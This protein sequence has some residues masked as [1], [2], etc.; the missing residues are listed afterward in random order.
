MHA[1]T[2]GGTTAERV[3]DWSPAWPIALAVLARAV[4]WCFV[5]EGRF[6]SDEESYVRAG[7][8]LLTR[9]EQDLFWPPFTGWLIAAAAWVFHTTDIR[10]IRLVWL[11]MDVACAV[12][13]GR[14]A[15]DV[16]RKSFGHGRRAALVATLATGM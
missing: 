2:A 3:A 13:L 5:P 9:G 14:L 1:G 10:W 6:A 16:A 8:G 7:I 4:A 12:L 15:H 11:A